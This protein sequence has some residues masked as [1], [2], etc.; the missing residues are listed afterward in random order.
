MEG[1]I[2]IHGRSLTT[3]AHA[4][5]GYREAQQATDRDAAVRSL[6]KALDRDPGFAMAATDLEYLASMPSPPLGAPIRT[7][8]RHHIEIVRTAG[9]GNLPRAR[10][11][12]IEHLNAFGCDPIAVAIAATEGGLSR[13]HVPAWTIADSP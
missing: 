9:A 2:D 5:A 1:S 13:C 6:R 11:L 8:E 12:L 7:W 3:N 10:L 4:A